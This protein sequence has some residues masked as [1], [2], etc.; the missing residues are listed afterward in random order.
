[1]LN[2]MAS[3]NVIFVYT[4]PP[5]PFYNQFN[6]SPLHVKTNISTSCLDSVPHIIPV[7]VTS[8]VCAVLADRIIE[9]CVFLEFG[10]IKYIVKFPSTVT[11][12]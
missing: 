5:L 1:M 9:K 6:H 4:M 12:D 3:L 2:P 10:S 8:L 7:S 11:F